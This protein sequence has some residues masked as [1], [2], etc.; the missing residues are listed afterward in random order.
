MSIIRA[1]PDG[2]LLFGTDNGGVSRYDGQEFVSLTDR[3][4]LPYPAAVWTMCREPDGTLWLGTWGDGVVRYDGDEFVSFTTEDGLVSR[5][6]MSIYRKPNGEMWFG[7]FFGDGVSRYELPLRPSTSLRDGT[8]WVSFATKDGFPAIMPIH[9][10][11][12]GRMWFR[13]SSGGICYYDGN[14]FVSFDLE[15]GLAKY[16]EMFANSVTD[17]GRRSF[18]FEGRWHHASD[19]VM[20]LV[21]G[22]GIARYDGQTFATLSPEDGLPST[23]ITAG[24]YSDGALWLGMWRGRGGVSPCASI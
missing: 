13:T 22:A 6:I 4:G 15:D 9:H 7:A 23:D 14:E 18:D 20:W 16:Y 10:D 1:E 8:E 24:R 19:G 17:N 11:P 12:G 2:T 3:D 21:T 5:N